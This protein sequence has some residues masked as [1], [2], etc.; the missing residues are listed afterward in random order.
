MFGAVRAGSG[1]K[2]AERELMELRKCGLVI[3]ATF[4]RSS[5]GQLLVGRVEVGVVHSI[6]LCSLE[7][8]S[9]VDSMRSYIEASER[10]ST[11]SD[12]PTSVIYSP[13]SAFPASMH[14]MYFPPGRE[15]RFH[16]HPGGRHLIIM[17]DIA[18]DIDHSSKGLDDDPSEEYST[19]TLDRLALHVVRFSA[20]TWHRFRT[21]G[22]SGA[23]VVAFS[24]HDRDDLVSGGDNLME[25]L[26]E[27]FRSA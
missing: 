23:G 25:E 8:G 13:E 2:L 10:R 26:T 19:L 12:L 22:G 27:F 5:V 15:Q 14:C 9:I 1:L 21:A 3:R 16:W 7:S 17:G 18:I 11:F 24:F 4:G 6:K 20:H